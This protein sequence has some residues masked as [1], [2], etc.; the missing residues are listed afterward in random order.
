VG[1]LSCHST[2]VCITRLV[3]RAKSDS[4]DPYRSCRNQNGASSALY[5]GTRLMRLTLIQPAPPTEG[6]KARRLDFES[7]MSSSLF[8][9]TP[10]SRIVKHKLFILRAAPVSSMPPPNPHPF[11]N[12]SVDPA[13]VPFGLMVP[14]KKVSNSAVERNRVRTRFKEA[15]R[16]VATGQALGDPLIL[17][18]K[19]LDVTRANTK[20]IRSRVYRDSPPRDL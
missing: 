9:K 1:A 18:G 14:K 19:Y 13:R 17:S 7:A 15:V 6:F 4:G 5:L 10:T 2:S 16:Q 20:G 11:P 12:S 8:R 3:G